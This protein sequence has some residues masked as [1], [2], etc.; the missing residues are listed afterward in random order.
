MDQILHIFKKDT[1]RHWPE[2]VIS[3]ALLALFARHEL[4][5]WQNSREFGSFSSFFLSFWGRYITAAL[6]LFWAFLIIRVIQGEPLVGDRQWWVTKPYEW[7]NLFLAKLLFFLIFICLPLFHVQIFLLHIFNFPILGNLRHL[8]LMQLALFFDLFVLAALLASLTKSFGQAL[9]TV[10]ALLVAG[11]GLAWLATTFPSSDDVSR[12]PVIVDYFQDCLVWGSLLAVPVLQFARRKRWTSLGVLAGAL[13]VNV[14]LGVVVPK[15]K[16]METEYPVAELPQAPVK[17]EI[18]P[19]PEIAG[20]INANGWSGAIPNVYLNIPISVSGVAPTSM[21]MVDLVKL[22]TDSPQDSRWSRGWK[23][24]HVELWP[25]DQ[26]KSLSYEVSRKEYEKVKTVPM[27]IHLELALSEY[28]ETDARLLI[29]PGD[30]FVDPTLGICRLSPRQSEWLECLN[31]FNEPG[32][33]ASLDPQRFPCL[34]E[35]NNGAVSEG[36][37]SHAWQF[38]NSS[39]FPDIGYSPIV[40]YTIWFRSA[41]LLT[42]PEKKTQLRGTSVVLC[43]GTE[44]RLAKPV[45]RRK[46]RIKLDMHSVRLQDLAGPFSW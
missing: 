36:A 3:L 40:D 13:A 16:T 11:I 6:V 44:I 35:E 45:L 27:N 4:N 25:E 30:K 12:P 20:R 43:P 21:V 34:K 31:T 17:I 46:L 7:W 1:R 22:T 15:T 18:R 28:Q 26:L 8:F 42:D 10:A 5:P 33:M 37:V 41:S 9:L 2:I 32:F 24:Q 14:L 19:I 38:Q 29:I 23:Y 39:G